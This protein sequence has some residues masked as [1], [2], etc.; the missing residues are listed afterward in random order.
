MKKAMVLRVRGIITQIVTPLIVRTVPC[1][2]QVTHA[3]RV[4]DMNV[5]SVPTQTEHPVR[6]SPSHV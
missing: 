2:S 3:E 6:I 5:V 4:S 1:V